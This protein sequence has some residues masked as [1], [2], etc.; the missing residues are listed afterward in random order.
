MSSIV[1]GDNARLNRFDGLYRGLKIFKTAPKIPT[2]IIILAA[3]LAIF[4]N[5]IAPF[6]ATEVHPR[7]S[8]EAP[9]FSGG[10]PEYFLGTDSQGRDILSRII[11]GTRTSLAVAI[12]SIALGGFVGTV[13]GL[14]AGYWGRWTDTIIMRVA[15]I[16]LAFP[17]ILIALVLA[18]TMGSG[19][20][21]VVV[22]LA[23][24][25]WARF[26][27][28]SRS[29]AFVFK[30]KDYVAMARVAGAPSH[31]ILRKHIFPNLINTMTVLATLMVGL[32][33]LVESSLSFLGAGIPP[34]TPTWGSMVAE[35]RTYV[36]MAWWMSLFPGIAIMVVVLAF[37]LFGDWLR[38]ALDPQLRQL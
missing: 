3:V 11:V 22:V 26:A 23:V 19:F 4:G 31:Y 8:R 35:G 34:P 30:E 17:A 10:K 9:A 24:S 6:P 38:D 27:R 28:L 25:M 1:R 12:A 7:D 32:A 15:D 5:L 16:T 18:V 37:N 33:I 14:I 13:M 2:A 21:V 29:E 36:S 20:K